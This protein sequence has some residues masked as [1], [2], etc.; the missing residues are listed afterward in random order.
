MANYNLP[1]SVLSRVEVSPVEDMLLWLLRDAFPEIPVHSLIPNETNDADFILARKN[2]SS[3]E[4]KT[5][6]TFLHTADIYIDVFTTG[7]EGDARA[8]LISEAVRVMLRNAWVN[9]VYIPNRGWVRHVICL[10]DGSLVSDWATT[11]GPV[12]YADLPNEYW[13]YQS[14][15]QFTWRRQTGSPFLTV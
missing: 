9:N 2:H 15:Y 10:E 14:Q 8:A 12:Q 11:G 6:E 7:P 1:N 3:G 5:N 4:P 13:R